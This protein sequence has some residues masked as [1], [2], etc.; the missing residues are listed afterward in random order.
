QFL[1]TRMPALEA[2]LGKPTWD[3]LLRQAAA[4]FGLSLVIHVTTVATNYVFARAL[5]IPL[6]FWDALALVPLVIL[7]GQ[8]PISPGRLGVREAGF[9][10]FL[11]RVGIEK[12][13]ALAIGLCWLFSLYLTGAIGAVLFLIDRRA[14]PGTAKL[15][16]TEAIPPSPEA[17][18]ASSVTPPGIDNP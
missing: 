4:V 12:E 17:E 18:D 8:L 11:S 1:A 3:S 10:Y 9:V 5:H 13:P 7:A 6:G 16:P 15:V 14:L 2:A